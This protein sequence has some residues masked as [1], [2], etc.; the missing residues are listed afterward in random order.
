MTVQQVSIGSSRQSLHVC[1]EWRLFG[2]AALPCVVQK[3][4]EFT[5]KLYVYG[6]KF[7]GYSIPPT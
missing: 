5:A 7:A 6:K 4:A 1:I 2:E 3:F